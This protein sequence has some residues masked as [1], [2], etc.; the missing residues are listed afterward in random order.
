MTVTVSVA[1]AM[2]ISI[3]LPITRAGIMYKR[4]FDRD[5]LVTELVP[6]GPDGLSGK[7]GRKLVKQAYK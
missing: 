1:I 3:V 6:H 7:L 4:S 2:A 5:G